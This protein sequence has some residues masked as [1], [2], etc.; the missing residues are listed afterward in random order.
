MATSPNGSEFAGAAGASTVGLLLHPDARAARHLPRERRGRDH[1]AGMVTGRARGGGRRPRRLRGAVERVRGPA[2]GADDARPARGARP[3]RGH[4]GAAVSPDGSRLAASDRNETRPTPDLPA[5]PAAFLA[6]W[7]TA[8][9]TLVGPPLELAVGA[10]TGRSDQLAF[11]PDGA[12][13][14]AGVLRRPGARPGHRDR[15]HDPDGE[16]AQRGH[17]GGLRPQRNPRTGTGAGTVDLWNPTTGQALAP[18]LIAASAPITSLAFEPDGQRFATA[19]YQDGAVKLWFVPTLQQEGPALPT[20]PGTAGAVA[21]QAPRAGPARR[22]GQRSGACLADGAVCLG[23]P[24]LSGRGAQLHARG[25]GASGRPARLRARLPLIA[26]GRTAMT[27]APVS[28]RT[29]AAAHPSAGPCGAM[30]ACAVAALEQQERGHAQRGAELGGG[31]ERSRGG[32]LQRLAPHWCPLRWPRRRRGRARCRPPRPAPPPAI[33]RSRSAMSAASARPTRTSPRPMTTRGRSA[34]QRRSG[35]TRAGDG[36]QAQR[37]QSQ[38]HRP[39]RRRWW[40]R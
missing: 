24:R 5:L 37:H 34:A 6:T 36:A 17:V 27:V 13:L 12:L 8:S 40:A 7:R 26:A 20:D 21:F 15:R 3:S 28:A 31:V 9:G 4:P 11:S 29:A 32:G 30:R 2:P 25:V 39:R 23:G 16:P 14:A 22:P 35:E 38:A 10:G 18:A 33:R 19:G 1:R